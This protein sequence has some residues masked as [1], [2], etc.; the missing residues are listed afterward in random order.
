MS[1]VLSAQQ[2]LRGLAAEDQLLT[3]E[4]A[5][6]PPAT[7]TQATRDRTL[8][9]VIRG[10]YIGTGHPQHPLIEVAA[11]T[12]RHPRAVAGVLTAAV[13]H[14]LTDAFARGTWLF[15]PLGSTPPRSQVDEVHAIQTSGRYILPRFDQT[16]DIVNLSVHGVDIRMTG[17]DRTT[18]DLWR[19]PNLV[20]SEHALTA[21]RRRVRADDFR[22]AGFARLARHL[23]IWNRVEPVVQGMML[24]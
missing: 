22:I 1:A 15:V 10:V 21:L 13:Y 2:R 19:Y 23:D 12:L 4:T 5:G 11:W 17:P 24:A 7:F 8:Q 9:R 16:N 14:Q 3:A 20:S 18:L 6:V